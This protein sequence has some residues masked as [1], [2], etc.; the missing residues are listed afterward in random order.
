M[1]VKTLKIKTKIYCIKEKKSFKVLK[2]C[3]YYILCGGDWE[4]GGK[5]EVVHPEDADVRVIQDS[6]CFLVS[7]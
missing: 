3:Y 5:S 2:P 1:W 4:E 7:C 6:I